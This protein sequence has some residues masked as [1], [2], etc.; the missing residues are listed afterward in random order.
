MRNNRLNDVILD[1]KNKRARAEAVREERLLEVHAAIPETAEIDK[2]IESLSLGILSSVLSGAD[3]DETVKCVKERTDKLKEE[4][5]LLLSNHGF[6]SDYTDI[7]YECDKCSDTG[8]VDFKSCICLKKAIAAANLEY[9]GLSHL[10]KTQT[11]ESFSLDYYE[12]GTPYNLAYKNFAFLK[13]FAENFDGKTGTSF[14][15]VGDT[16][17]GKTHL[18]T[19]VAK[20]VM[21]K[22]FKVAYDSA[23]DI[24]ADFEAEKFKGTVSTEEINSRY[25]ES[26]LLIID[27][28]GCEMI[29]QFT[30]SCFYNLIN[31][32]LNRG[33]STVINTNLNQNELREKYTD[34]ITS[35]IFG[36]YKILLFKGTDIRCQKLK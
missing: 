18:S 1:F 2:E 17:L 14:L 6:A 28:L 33:L 4:R 23:S 35:R 21:D 10:A 32:R 12:K 8:F 31:S 15:L 16:G 7:H 36:N 5:S 19:A 24:V 11:F 9:S 20:T 22:G 25:L 29:T 34:R 3:P 26:A 30:V 13:S 27:D